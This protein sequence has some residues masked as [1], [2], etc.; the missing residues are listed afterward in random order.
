MLHITDVMHAGEDVPHVRDD[1]SLS[2]ALV[3]MSRKRLGMTAVVD[4]EDRLL[5][6]FTD[7]DLRRT[8]DNPA[9]DVRTAM[10]ADLM[11]R[12]PRTIGADQL[13]AEAARLME[14]HKI[15]GLIVVDREGRAVGALNIH[16]LL[17]ARVV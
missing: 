1:A 8:L 7:G 15:S 16:D 14:T 12:N 9:L 17:R 6:L 2:E 5:G 13:A 3:E 11:T 4:G 10:I